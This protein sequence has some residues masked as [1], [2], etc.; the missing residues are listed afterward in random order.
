MAGNWLSPSPQ[1]RSV[2]LSRSTLGK[3]SR[4]QEDCGCGCWRKAWDLACGRWFWALGLSGAARFLLCKEHRHAGQS[5][6]QPRIPPCRESRRACPASVSQV[7]NLDYYSKDAPPPRT[8]QIPAGSPRPSSE[9]SQVGVQKEGG[10]GEGPH[11]WGPLPCHVLTACQRVAS[12]CRDRTVSD[13]G[14]R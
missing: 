7:G 6:E 5:R 9:M 10:A 3:V 12:V 8:P 4:A 13:L 14:P 2:L 1:P 11:F